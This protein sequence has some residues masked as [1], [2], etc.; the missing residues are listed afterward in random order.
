MTHVTIHQW[1]GPQE[2]QAVHEARAFAQRRGQP[3]E[4]LIDGHNDYWVSNRA[5]YDPGE[6]R[7]VRRVNTD[8]RVVWV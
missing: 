1:C 4:I 7:P 6:L 2:S 5:D 8:G 3:V